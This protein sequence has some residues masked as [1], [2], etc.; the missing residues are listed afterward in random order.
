ME[1]SLVHCRLAKKALSDSVG[2]FVLCGKGNPGCQWNLP[3]DNCMP[4]EKVNARIE[5]VHRAALAVGAAAGFS[6]Q[7]CHNRF[8]RDPFGNRVGM[9]PVA[10]QDVIIRTKN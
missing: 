2:T 4:A 5:Q 7:L 10:G 9:L 1:A 8:R 6:V 3:T